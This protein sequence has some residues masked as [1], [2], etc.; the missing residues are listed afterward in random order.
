MVTSQ[1]QP[2]HPLRPQPRLPLPSNKYT[3]NRH[4]LTGPRPMRVLRALM[5][6]RH[7]TVFWK[8]T[9]IF[10]R[11]PEEIRRP[12]RSVSGGKRSVI[13]KR[14]TIVEAHYWRFWSATIIGSVMFSIPVVMPTEGFIFLSASKLQSF[15]SII[16]V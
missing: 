16:K 12:K 4:H 7:W 13:L 10:S 2:R 3:N 5:D 8:L 11:K 6:S 15:D 1:Q 9:R 14:K